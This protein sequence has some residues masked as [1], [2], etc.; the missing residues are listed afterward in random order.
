MKR[1]VLLLLVLALAGTSVFAATKYK[2]APML[3]DLVKAGKLPSVDKRLPDKPIVIKP[4]E[5][6]GQ[7]GG[8][9]RMVSI[10]KDW[11]FHISALST[12][13]EPL[14]RSSTD[15]K[16]Y[17]PGL[18]ESWEVS[19]DGKTYTLH[20][21]K[22][23]KWSDGQPFNA[24][25]L[26]FW[27]NDVISNKELTP[28]L[29][30]WLQAGGESCKLEKVN[31]TTV[32]FVFP[33]TNAFFLDE[34]SYRPMATVARSSYLP[35][36]YLKQFHPKYA[37][38]AKLDAA[39]KAAGFD[40]WTKL[41]LNQA[42]WTVNPALP[43]MCAWKLLEPISAGTTLV[44]LER[45]PYYIKVD[46]AGNQLPYIDKLRWEIVST[47]DLTFFK[48]FNGEID[49]Q[50]QPM[51]SQSNNYPL[52]LENRARGNYRVIAAPTMA[53]NIAPMMFN[54]TSKDPVLRQIFQDKRFRQA[55]SY[56]IDRK[57][58]AEMCFALGDKPA[59]VAQIS[60]LE[61]SPVYSETLSKQYTEFDPAKAN[62][63]LDEVGLDKKDK[64]GYRL[65]PDGKLLELVYESPDFGLKGTNIDSEYELIIGFLQKVGIK[66][67]L[68]YV[69][70]S[71]WWTRA[72]AG[73][74]DWTPLCGIAGGGLAPINMSDLNL[75]APRNIGWETLWCP[76]WAQWA[77]TNGASGEEPIP[78]VKQL[79][80]L[81]RQV[82]TTADPTKRKALVEQI[83]KINQE[84]FFFLGMC[85]FTDLYGVVNT[86]MKN[87]PDV[88]WI[89]SDIGYVGGYINPCQIYFAE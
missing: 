68:K 15:L 56:A 19:K 72:Q 13:Y 29:P 89:H 58:I 8:T 26:M 86:K 30:T 79:I 52:T 32:R 59:T 16:G 87:V 42:D 70:Y 41:F 20:F 14:V 53:P 18:A 22:G 57:T 9:W 84:Q 24:D 33:K 60:P 38:K 55:F 85:R 48:T 82:E 44:N 43:T 36:H 5:R 17:A 74:I 39:V 78:V 69:E 46:T 88:V 63:L 21:P 3:T 34:L 80:D 65:R 28:S 31:D 10:G 6:V 77:F 27:F 51:G 12:A 37:D 11:I 71:L 4:L 54:L 75:Y 49:F 1:L 81:S 50:I 7:Y 45:N 35:A 64:D 83:L 62:Q 61:I 76:Q 66:C 23:A 25:D 47:Q 40:S 73:D 2:E 67:T